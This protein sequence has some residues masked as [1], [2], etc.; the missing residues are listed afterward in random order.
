MSIGYDFDPESKGE[1]AVPAVWAATDY[2]HFRVLRATPEYRPMLD[3][4][5]EAITLYY[6]VVGIYEEH[7]K[8]GGNK[9]H[10]LELDEVLFR[11][12]A[13]FH[14]TAEIRIVPT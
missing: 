9:R 1:A 7:E 11:V 2:G 10:R 4:I 13:S 8:K 14:C 12:S 5:L 6:T 3:K